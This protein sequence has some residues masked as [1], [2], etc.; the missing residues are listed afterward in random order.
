MPDS[1]QIAMLAIAAGLTSHSVGRLFGRADVVRS[2]QNFIART[3]AGLT[4]VLVKTSIL[5]E[6]AGSFVD[7]VS[8]P[9]ASA[10]SMVSDSAD[11]YPANSQ[12]N[13]E[14]APRRPRLGG[15]LGGMSKRFIDVL[16]ATLAL[17]L[18][19]PLLLIIVT[20]I[21]VTMG[22]P[23]LFAHNRIGENGA[24][25][26]CFKF[27]SMANN[28]PEILEHHLATN[29]EA[30]REWEL[31]QKLMDDPRVTWLGHL[32]RKSSIDELP[33]LIN[34]LRGEM[35]CIGPRPIVAEEVPRYGADAAYYFKA[36]PG[37]TGLWQVS[38]RSRLS[39][40]ERVALDTHYVCNWSIG[41]DLKILLKTVPVLLKFDD[42]A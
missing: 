37:L 23:V 29:P 14:R 31:N 20:L 39:Y 27:R 4:T 1:I 40:P 21:L 26:P 32:M 19:M 18:L 33:Q 3:Y 36:R 16:I 41:L 42:T 25:F 24:E 8:V 6:A 35:S 5:R 7:E 12:E 38:G 11:L 15:S 22:R 34:V 30:A 28:S 10:S 13:S 9:T 17:I 2:I